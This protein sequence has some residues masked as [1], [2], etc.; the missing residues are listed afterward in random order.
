MNSV[1]KGAWLFIGYVVMITLGFS[2]MD[3]LSLTTVTSFQFIGQQVSMF[4]GLTV[5]TTGIVF[6]WNLL[7]AK[8]HEKFDWHK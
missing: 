5:V 1:M 7:F 6:L 2:L 8:P 3:I 4:V